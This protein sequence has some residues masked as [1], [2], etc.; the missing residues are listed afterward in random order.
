MIDR[1]LIL[2]VVDGSSNAIPIIEI[3]HENKDINP[4]INNKYLCV[5]L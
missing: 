3:K 5:P 4:P 1:N 2:I